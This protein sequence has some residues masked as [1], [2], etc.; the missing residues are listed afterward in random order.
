MSA[1]KQRFKFGR[2]F[3][4]KRPVSGPL[5]LRL[6]RIYILPT[7]SGLGL[8]FMIIL[9][10]LVAFIDNNNL[11]YLL[12]FLLASVFFV[13]MLHTCKQLAGLV[14]QAGYVQPVFAGEAAA[15]GVTVT[16][17]GNQGHP[18]LS[19]N[20]EGEHDFNLDA[21][22]SRTLMLPVTMRKRGWRMMDAVTLASCYPLGIFR[23]WTPLRFDCKVLVYP[24]PSAVSLPFPAGEGRALAGQGHVDRAGRDD[25]NG[26][27]PYQSGDSLS[28]IHWKAYAKGQGLLSKQYA[29]DAGGT[30]LWLE[31]DNTPGANIEERL[32]RL[33]RWVIDAEQAGLRYGLSIPGHRLTPD[34]GPAHQ[35][36]CL[37]A[38]ALF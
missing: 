30:E 13:A 16:N 2:F 36:A 29:T 18:A 35:A 27:R 6:R 21:H 15:F 19:A 38:L 34:H 26:A 7:R 8:A 10:L 31:Y 37:E 17:P 14:V 33:C 12:A 22:E 23:A 9:L 28:H 11:I 32:S 5:E 25:F 3:K 4:N 24:K 1:F 20:L